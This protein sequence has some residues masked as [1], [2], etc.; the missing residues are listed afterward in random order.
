[1]TEVHIDFETRCLLDLRKVGAFVYAQHETTRILCIAFA[2]DNKEPEI[3]MNV[4]LI[5]FVV[6][7]TID[8]LLRYAEDESTTFVAH[9]AAF[10]QNIWNEVL[11]KRFGYPELPINRW[12]CTMAKAYYFGLPGGLDQ[13][14]AA[15]ELDVRKDT[16]G[17]KIMQVLSRPKD[18]RTQNKTGSMFWEY[19]ER[20]EDFERLYEYCKQDV[21]TEQALDRAL[22][23]D[24][25]PLERK[26]WII[27][28]RIN[29]EGLRI[30]VPFVQ[31][32]IDISQSHK[33]KLMGDFELATGFQVGAPSQRGKFKTWLE[34]KGVD[35]VDTKR[36]TFEALDLDS[37]PQNVQ[38]A[39]S[40]TNDF[41]RSSVAKY[42]SMMIRSVDGILREMYQY[43]GA[44]T[45][46]WAGRGV[47]LHNMA[48]P[49]VDF[50]TVVEMIRMVG[51]EALEW[52]Y[53]DVNMALSSASRGAI[54]PR[55]G[56]RFFCGDFAQMEARMLAWLAGEDFVL[57]LFRN[58]V[59]TYCT[60]ASTIF[61]REITKD[62][63][64]ERHIGK[65]SELALGYGGGIAAYAAMAASY[66]TDLSSMARLV[67]A[68]STPFER[69]T[70]A[71]YYQ[72]YLKR[73]KDNKVKH[74]PVA[75]EIGYA[76]NIVKDRWREN[77]PVTVQYWAD[78]ESTAIEAV[79]TGKEVR[80]RTGSWF[81]HERFLFR[82]FASGRCMAYPYP[83]IRE[84]R[85]GALELSYRRVDPITKKWVR[86]TTY[87]GQLVENETQGLQ[88]DL[89]RDAMIR[90]ETVY[91][92][93]MHTHDELLSEVPVGTGDLA[94]FQKFMAAPTYWSGTY[95][96]GIPIDVDVWEGMRYRK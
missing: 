45:G 3:L 62:D 78:M 32:A 18:V 53:G 48:R 24:L 63:K 77:R 82:K 43:Y 16:D 28:Q 31:K 27:D 12:R 5:P 30:D 74:P 73:H 61:T 71:E 75:P 36:T 59:D 60:A 17:A 41:N 79:I 56:T 38:D 14:V 35:T 20:P 88:R 95:H 8:K 58:K 76:C 25:E 89:L 50:D 10:E 39:I 90:L 15:M 94:E 86:N 2:E 47:Q 84:K 49:L 6:D 26:T 67:L 92:V 40:I 23:H 44:H 1:M 80:C 68:A 51:Y 19:D 52:M 83:K 72:M 85:N 65:I 21:R 96:E 34:G 13:A 29:R 93:C 81:M 9:N 57:D 7:A 22:P 4:G 46:R 69:E 37:L 87:G 66:G 54:I 42:S 70:A 91:P 55:D 11:V 33:L 64:E